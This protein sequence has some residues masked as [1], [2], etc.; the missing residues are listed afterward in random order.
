MPF[1]RIYM[2][3]I[4]QITEAYQNIDFSQT[5]A[6]LATVVRVEGSSYRRTGARMLV[7]E[8]G[9][10]IGGISGGCLEGDALK[11][12][13]LAMSQNKATLITYDTTDD[14]PYQIGVGLGCN[15]IIDVLITPL[16]PKNA[17]NAVRQLQNCIDQ[18]TPNLVVT[19]TNLTKEQ[20]NI[21]L[22]DVFRYDNEKHFDEIF[23]LNS[24]KSNILSEIITALASTKS[25]A[26][27]YVLEDGTKINLFLEVIPPAIQLYVFG[28]NY[29]V[30]P[31]VKV[32][33]E[34][35]WR[36]V[37]ICNPTKMHASLFELADAVVPKD[38]EPTIDA[39]TAAISMCH[40]YE[41]DY[42]NLQLLLKTNISYI[43]LLGP[44]KR[45]IK[46]YD[47]MAEENIVLTNEQENRI[48]SPVGL[49]IGAA[50]PE[51]IALSV[52]AEI[53]AA[54]SGREGSRLRLRE[55]PIY[56]N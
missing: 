6:A 21:S 8:S 7:L 20:S 30:Y 54:F 14:D 37:C 32:A 51:E 48:Y 19:V 35:G 11:K 45:T 18:R 49:D 5:R 38:Y 43:G 15:G 10:W 50:T 29:D 23:P 25:V 17:N 42:R 34:L 24:L 1:F 44:K 22:G 3:E 26:K 46:M 39:F 9:E 4:K 55:K 40:D 52:C 53:R 13:R 16:D 27:E 31:M 47:R 2:K 36:V 41:S 56:E 28:S 33:K 12:A